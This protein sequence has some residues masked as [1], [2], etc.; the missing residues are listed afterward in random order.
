MILIPM[1][2]AMSAIYKIKIPS[3]NELP[4]FTEHRDT[5][6]ILVPCESHL[7]DLTRIWR[8][9]ISFFQV[10]VSCA[11][12]YPSFAKNGGCVGVF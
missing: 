2:T 8:G 1:R 10:F 6:D 9:H 3:T 7:C 4:Y 12:F 11:P 5:G